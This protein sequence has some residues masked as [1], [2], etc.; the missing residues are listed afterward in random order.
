[1]RKQ[2]LLEVMAMD[3]ERYEGL[4]EEQDRPTPKDIIRISQDTY[5]SFMARRHGNRFCLHHWQER[6]ALNVGEL[7][8]ISAEEIRESNFPSGRYCSKCGRL[9][10]NESRMAVQKWQLTDFLHI[11]RKTF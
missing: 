7:V 11:V 1:M 3:R 8:V 9:D 10:F 6:L 2:D 5:D 4:V